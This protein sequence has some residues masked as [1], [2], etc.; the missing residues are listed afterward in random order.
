MTMGEDKVDLTSCDR[1]PIHRLGQIQDFGALIAVTSDWNVAFRSANCDTILQTRHPLNPGDRAEDHFSS[2]ALA[3]MR[4]C[5]HY[6]ED[7]NVDV[8]RVFG[9]ELLSNGHDFDIA[10]HRSGRFI[11][12][13]AEPSQPGG[14]AHHTGV[15]RQM[16][17]RLSQERDVN[18]LCNIAAA[19][20]KRLLGFDRVMVYRFHPDL[21]GE[22]VAEARESRLEAFLH[23]RYPKT[24]IPAQARE[25]YL[26][27]LFRIISDVNAEPVD[28]EPATDIEGN[29][30][31]LSLSSLRAVSRIHIEYLQNMGVAASLSI[32]IVIGGKLWGLFACH[33]YSPILLPFAQRTIAELF[34]QLFA[35]RLE[36]ATISAGSMMKDRARELHDRLM[37]Q[38]IGGSSL[39]DNL[40]IINSAIRSI[41]PHD[42]L[43][44]YIDGEYRSRGS[45]PDEE[46]FL[47]LVPSL[48]TSSTSSLVHSDSISG[49]IPNAS[50]FADRAVG[51]LIIP[52]SR[53]PRDYVTLWRRELPQ[54]VTWAGNPEKVASY[55]PNGE[56]LTP[57]KS[58]AAWQESVSGRSAPWSEEELAIAEGLRV[59]LLE[60]ILRITD[61]QYQ[62]RTRANERQ[63]LLIAEL[64]HRVRNIL[65]L[66]RGLVGQSKSEASSIE[67]FA[68]MIGG[69]IRA[70]S[71]A[72]DHITRQQWSPASLHDL[73]RAEAEAYLSEKVSRVRIT[74]DDALI[75]PEGFT[76]LALVIHEMMTNSAKYGS[77]C[78]QTGS[79]D[80]ET[81]FDRHGDYVIA[82]RESGGP[83]VKAPVR[84]GFGS[85]IIEKSIP[86]ELKGA[87][88]VRY[89]LAGLEAD[90][91]VPARLVQHGSPSA[92]RPGDT[93]QMQDASAKPITRKANADRKAVLVVEDSMIIA[94]DAEDMLKDMGFPRVEV[95]SNVG[96]ALDWL[97][98]NVP[99]FALLDFNLGDET[100]EKVAQRLENL[101]VPFWFVTG[102]GD[103]MTKLSTTAAQGVL[104]KPYAQSDIEAAFAALK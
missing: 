102:Y 51:A 60:V 84:R 48:N 78:D 93:H 5:V 52:V 91:I 72:H 41:I 69:R 39:A 86:F 74:G 22:V 29:S 15:L 19:Q 23:L 65:T 61:E 104:Q 28:I 58:F 27:N 32:S 76:V 68:D 80:I 71:M 16:M 53:R 97:S 63:D 46:Q 79:L 11:I 36:V 101:D 62:E 77:L 34:A 99:Q 82:W 98:T 40:D 8:E 13:E 67:E 33:H 55:G 59:T 10:L 17:D 21:S 50:A 64:N 45:A 25:L 14:V 9:L 4:D 100:S 2:E 70:L 43:S 90:F 1:E 95:A 87:A 56:R 85:T 6:L 92:D 3:R 24:D 12:I 38:L 94:M 7:G 47:R 18:A 66:I 81:H 37:S 83:P 54:V 88:D 57:R 35:Q 20:L 49:V 75:Q 30:L 44:A 96:A 103:A 73:I 31:D 42:G 26:R 89:N